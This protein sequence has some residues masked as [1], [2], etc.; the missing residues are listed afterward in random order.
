M[1]KSISAKSLI[2]KIYTREVS[3][4]FTRKNTF[5]LPFKRIL[6]TFDWTTSDTFTTVVNSGGSFRI[7]FGGQMVVQATQIPN[8]IYSVKSAKDFIIPCNKA[9]QALYYH[10]I[11]HLLYTDMTD[12]R[13]A[14]YKEAKYRGFIHSIFNITEDIV[15][16]RYGM[17][18]DHPE[19][20]K[21]FKFLTDAV[22]VPQLPL[23]KDD[24]DNPSAFLNYLLLRLRCG[25]LFK[26]TSKVW[27]DHKKDLV[28]LTKAILEEENPT[29]RITKSIALAEY[30][31]K[32]TKWDFSTVKSPEN[33]TSGSVPGGSGGLPAPAS[34]KGKKGKKKPSKTTVNEGGGGGE[35]EGE[36]N[37]SGTGSSSQNRSSAHTSTP[38]KTT[39]STIDELDKDVEDFNES[40]E[41]VY[42]PQNDLLLE[43]CPEID[44][45][46]NDVLGSGDNHEFL[47]AKQFFEPGPSLE[48][49]I[50][51]MVADNSTLATET[52]K[53][54]SVYKGRIRPRFNRGF[55][56]G[57]LDMNKAMNNALTGGCDL[58]LFQR[59]I[60]NGNAPDLAISVL[61]DNSGSMSGN[62]SHVCT[63]A[64]IALA[65]ACQ[66]CK[67][68]LEI[69]CFTERGG[70]N[71]TIR[72]KEF[73][74]DFD[75]A[76]KYFG[77]TDSNLLQHYL[78]DYSRIGCFCGN[79]DEVNLYYL[80]KEFQRNRHKD[81]LMIVI[82]D[83]ETCGDTQTLRNLINEITKSKIAI[84]GL[85]IQSRA[86]ESIYPNY[87]LFDTAQSLEKLPEY[88][89][90]TLFKFAKGGK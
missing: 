6:F 46:F 1:A 9:F 25:K 60:K 79:E 80:W 48:E 83:G 21:Y 59:K 82:S 47:L 19:T 10:E 71:K 32:N 57:R 67:I 74:D 42:D 45:A 41:D 26:G 73:D 78:C 24:P 16:E 66:L 55:V 12:R 38:E 77:I 40:I 15:M 61:C 27:E 7:A 29:E 88:L 53:S 23:Y 85:G 70:M 62:K 11:G 33:P 64:M 49:A 51:K 4:V 50:N 54:L 34:V 5:F 81:K 56:S 39:A 90:T 35:E 17:S 3:K 58:K 75:T 30:L 68:P 63:I 31:I 84:V 44:D 36:S 20:A 2:T 22:F 87:K 76:K 28:P 69:S 72:I 89:T 37:L 52:S 14:D 13:I 43:G 18:Y 65:R 8:Q 86:V